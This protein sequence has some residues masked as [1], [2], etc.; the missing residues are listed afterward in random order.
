[1][2]IGS[3]E[4]GHQEGTRSGHATTF[5]CHRLENGGRLQGT[6]VEIQLRMARHARG[7]GERLQNGI[8][9]VVGLEWHG[10]CEAVVATFGQIG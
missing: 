6:S 5:A 2:Q 7:E 3:S 4:V 9:P 8:E 10:P 1:M